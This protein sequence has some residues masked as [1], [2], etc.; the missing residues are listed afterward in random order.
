MLFR[1][2]RRRRSL[3]LR[4]RLRVSRRPH[5]LAETHQLRP[6]SHSRATPLQRHRRA[7]LPPLVRLCPR[8]GQR[9]RTSLAHLSFLARTPH[10]PFRCRVVCR[11]RSPRRS[12]APRRPP[13][14]VNRT[15]RKETKNTHHLPVGFTSRGLFL[16]PVICRPPPSVQV[17]TGRVKRPRIMRKAKFRFHENLV[18]CPIYIAKNSIRLNPAVFLPQ[19]HRLVISI[20]YICPRNVIL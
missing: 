20:V 11:T 16:C 8:R 13:Q 19:N 2:L 9:P 18:F 17:S 14:C 5:R 12:F 15:R 3:S 10:P 6:L 1:T 7:Q 4:H